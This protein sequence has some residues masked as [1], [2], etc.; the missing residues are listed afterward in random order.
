M[1]RAGALVRP[2]E[3]VAET[4]RL[5]EE[6]REAALRAPAGIRE[7]FL[8]E[9]DADLRAAREG[10]LVGALLIGPKDEAVALARFETPTGLPR[11]LRWSF[12]EGYANAA[13]ARTF[14]AALERAEGPLLGVWDAGEGYAPE[15]AREALRSAGFRRTQRTDLVFPTSAPLPPRSERPLPGR[16]RAL[17]P[18]DDEPLARLLGRAYATNPTDRALFVENE[19]PIAEANASVRTLLHGGVG[20]WLPNASFVVEAPDGFA[21]A[22]LACDLRGPLVAEVMT[23]PAWR[24]RGLARAVLTETLYALRATDPRVPRLVVTEGNGTADRLYRSLG[25]VDDPTAVGAIWLRPEVV[26]ALPRYPTD[27]EGG[28]PSPARRRP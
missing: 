21:S 18:D 15:G 4:L 16:L 10:R 19:D 3:A 7:W 6:R 8:E 24:G 26:A 5:L 11:R 1:T 27:S 13:T 17:D 25:F 9:V 14:L 20:A 23:D 12:A 28:A 2:S 22:T